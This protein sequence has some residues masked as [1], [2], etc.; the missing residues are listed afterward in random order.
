MDDDTQA[1]CRAIAEWEGLAPK[2]CRA[3]PLRE[4]GFCNVHSRPFPHEINGPDYPHDLDA[5]MR[6]A[7]RLLE[8]PEP[9]ILEVTS[10]GHA[11]ICFIA[12]WRLNNA[13]KIPDNPQLAAFECLYEFVAAQ[14]KEK[15]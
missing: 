6:A 8:L 14:R 5:T 7:R 2:L 3:I 15:V 1:K 13:V 9:L 10:M 4:S 11:R 12:N